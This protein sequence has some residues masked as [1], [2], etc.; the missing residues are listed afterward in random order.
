MLEDFREWQL[1]TKDSIDEWTDKLVKEALKRQLNW[2]HRSRNQE[3]QGWP[4]GPIGANNWSKS[5]SRMSR[6]WIR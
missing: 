5:Q 6:R 2:G 4:V 1:A 3:R